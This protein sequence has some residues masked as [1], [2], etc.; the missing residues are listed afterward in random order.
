MRNQDEKPS[1][2]C[3]GS[4]VTF[5]CVGVY[6]RKGQKLVLVEMGSGVLKYHYLIDK[7]AAASDKVTM[8]Q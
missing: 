5:L 8:H 1:F 4:N 2:S 6:C 3:A 7:F